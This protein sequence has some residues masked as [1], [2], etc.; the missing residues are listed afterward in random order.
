M[1][2]TAQ[3]DGRLVGGR[4][5]LTRVL[6]RGG[7][8]TVWAGH[9]ELLNRDVA[10]KELIPPDSLDEAERRVVR[11]RSLREARAAARIS[12]PGAVMVY[13]VV[14]EDDRPWIVM[15]QLHARS[16]A[17]VLKTD[18]PLPARAAAQVGLDVVEALAAAHAAGV[19]HRDVKPANVMLTEDGAVLTDFGIATLE[20][21][22]TITATGMIVGSPAYMSP[23][24]ARGEAPTAA[25]DFWSLGAMLCAAVSGRS[26]FQR[27][28]NLP[29]LAAVVVDPVDIPDEAGPLRPVLER[30][31]AKDPADRPDAATTRAMLELAASGPPPEAPAPPETP[32][33]PLPAQPRKA[34]SASPKQASRV[35]A[36]VAVVAVLAGVVAAIVQ[37]TGD[38]DDRGRAGAGANPKPSASAPASTAPSAS[39]S[40]PAAQPSASASASAPVPSAGTTPGAG[41]GGGSGSSGNSGQGTSSGTAVPA[42]FE[43]RRDPTGFA[44]AVPDGWQRSVKKT[45][46]RYTEPGGSRYLMVDQT[47]TPAD[48]V[49]ADWT[50]Q[51]A[52]V[53]KKFRDYEKI[54]L[55]RVE[56]K[57]LEAADWEFT[58]RS[59]NRTIHV[60]NRNIRVDDGQAYALYWSVPQEQWTASRPLFDTMAASFQPK[61]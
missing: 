24:R 29:T 28:G 21:D 45:Q 52:V 8:G 23:E 27:N 10:V 26:P 54:S 47:T 36:I 20:G 30:L 48:D 19:L 17:D 13:D 4:Y 15:Q 18:G 35:L 58:W 46:T 60:L 40:A 57:G 44:I 34:S 38:D 14:E 37:L 11:E 22:P 51:E 16:L 31:L 42:G 32:Q 6:G 56:Y 12:H 49:L 5:R 50:D 43:L 1:T 3:P 55:A 33:R 7:M 9:D 59:G 39:A 2:V 25:A 53:S 41:S 61:R